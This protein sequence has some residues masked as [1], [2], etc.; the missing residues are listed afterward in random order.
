[1]DVNPALKAVRVQS[2]D[3]GLKAARLIDLI[4]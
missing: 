4:M 1:M 2:L 3:D